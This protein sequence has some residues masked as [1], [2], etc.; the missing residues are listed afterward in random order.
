MS[1][2]PQKEAAR[3][4]ALRQLRLLDTA[5][6]ESYDRITRIAARLFDLPI[7][8]VSLTDRDR[9]WFKSSIGLDH[10]SIP[11]CGAPCSAVAETGQFLVIPDLLEDP[12]YRDGDLAR[13]GVRFY[14]GAPLVTRDGY[15]LGAL[16]VLGLEPRQATESETASLEDLA[17]MVIAQMEMEHA[18]GRIDPVSGL[19][20]R[21]RLIED[22]GDLARD[23]PGESAILVL[24]DVARVDEM[25]N[26]LRVV[27]LSSL[28]DTARESARLLRSVL[29][30]DRTIYQVGAKQFAFLALP[31]AQLEPY[32]ATL[33][34]AM[35]AAHRE[36]MVGFGT[37]PAIGV[38][39]FVHGRTDPRDVLRTAYSA[40]EDAR[41]VEGRVSVYST[42]QDAVHQRR[43]ALQLAFADALTTRGELR[44]VFQPRIDLPTGRCIGAEALLR[45]THPELGEVSPGEFVP[46]V[47]TTPL[48]RDM[49]D[50][51]LAAAVAQLRLWTQADLDLSLSVNISAANLREADFAD[52]LAA[53]MLASRIEPSRLEL[54]ITESAVMEDSGAALAQLEAIAALGV[55]LAID[56]FGTGYSSLAYLQKLP[57]DVVKIDQAFVRD[58]DDAANLTLVTSMIELS[59]AL[60]Y[61]VVAE[62]VETPD[63]AQRLSD[64]GCDEAQ[65]YFY[66]RP[67]PARDFAAWLNA[68]GAAAERAA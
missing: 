30:P 66:A 56:D 55:R 48:A 12:T 51:V 44:L 45:W 38:S 49:T 46:I 23:R 42:D 22:L 24:V 13:G 4:D 9:Q 34:P 31:G 17:T 6:S 15:G 29:G 37:T 63:T 62:G 25:A 26:A 43:Y 50:W 3:L 61:G 2:D 65:G 53:R 41:S 19:P 60:G 39:P 18:A 27:G 7:C 58:L 20:N 10:R 68:H 28:D 36:A 8:A 16:C 59:H 21:Q 11:R 5:P 64:A 52:R 1:I 40:A 67:M 14:A 35:H 32:V 33:S 54:E 47:E 57:A